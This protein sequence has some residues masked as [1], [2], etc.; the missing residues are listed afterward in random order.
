VIDLPSPA[1]G[2]VGRAS[3]LRAAAVGEAIEAP[4]CGGAAMYRRIVMEQVGTFNPYLYAD[5]EPELCLRIRHQG[6]RIIH[7]RCP[8][9]NHYT[10]PNETLSSVISRRRRNFYLGCGQN[11][12]YHAGTELLWQYLR[13]RGFAF[14]PGFALM[15][16][17]LSLLW[18]LTTHQWLWFG[19]WCLLVAVFVASDARRKHSFYRTIVSLIKRLFSIEGTVRGLLL[20]PLPPETY[21]AS[22]DVIQRL[23]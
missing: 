8:M 21:P 5:E 10:E 12:R 9:V 2:C 14:I 3:T 16:G 6:Y 18:S 13:E 20:K 17:L 19:S 1:D 15:A 22:L 23:D 7:I 4:I 11:I